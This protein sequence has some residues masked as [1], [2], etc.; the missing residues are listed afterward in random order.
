M[1]VHVNVCCAA[2]GLRVRIHSISMAE[3]QRRVVCTLYRNIFR[4][5]KVRPFQAQLV[6]SAPRAA[7]NACDC[8][9]LHR[10]EASVRSAMV[11]QVTYNTR[12]GAGPECAECRERPA[13]ETLGT[14]ES[15]IR[16]H[17]AGIKRSACLPTEDFARVRGLIKGRTAAL[18]HAAAA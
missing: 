15:I 13:G 12:A 10:A 4:F 1:C 5:C 17:V 11:P 7:Q 8:V 14:P 18:P 6:L 16:L 2:R 3:A 9:A